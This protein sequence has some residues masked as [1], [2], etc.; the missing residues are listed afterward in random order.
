MCKHM[1]IY[2]YSYVYIHICDSFVRMH[3][4]SCKTMWLL[5]L[6]R[7]LHTDYMHIMIEHGSLLLGVGVLSSILKCS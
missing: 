3:L 4:C 7:T 1:Y 6:Q 5:Q 2:I